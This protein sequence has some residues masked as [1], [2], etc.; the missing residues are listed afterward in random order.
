MKKMP[1]HELR[2]IQRAFGV[3]C[4]AE[5]VWLRTLVQF[6]KLVQAPAKFLRKRV[7]DQARAERHVTRMNIL[8]GLN[9]Q[10]AEVDQRI[11]ALIRRSVIE[12]I[13]LDPEIEVASNHKLYLEGQIQKYS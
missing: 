11:D 4:V 6:F 9:V 5:P 1:K 12:K 7:A 2:A 10:L 3:P 13:N 8:A